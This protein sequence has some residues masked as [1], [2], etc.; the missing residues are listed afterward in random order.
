MSPSELAISVQGL[1]KSYPVYASPFDAL[2]EIFPGRKHHTDLPVL[3]DIS[4][5]VRRGERVG[6]VGANGAGKS[7]LLK[8][9]SGTV[10]HTSGSY[11]VEGQLRAILELGTGFHEE[12]TGRENILL[13]GLCLGYSAKD[14]S[15]R[16]DWIIEFSELA[17][18]MDRPLRTYSSGMKARLMYSVAFCKP[19]EIMIIDE[20]LA[21]GDASFVRKCTNH[22]V[23]LCG[24]GTTALIV[25]HNLY[26]LERI[27]HRVVYLADGKLVADGDPLEVC[28]LY[29]ADQGRAFVSVSTQSEV[30]GFKRDETPAPQADQAAPILSGGVEQPFVED[31]PLA[32]GLF[33][34]DLAPAPPEMAPQNGSG[35]IVGDDGVLQLFDFSGAPAVRHLNLVRLREAKLFDEQGQ[36]AIEI[37]CGRPCRVRFVLESRVVKRDVHIGF[38]IWN[39]GGDHVA[40]STNVCSLD[41]LGRPNGARI[42]LAVGLLSVDVVFPSLR[43]GAGRYTL[44]FGVSPGVEHYSDDDLFVSEARCLAFSVSRPDHVQTVFYEPHSLWSAPTLLGDLPA[45]AESAE[46][47]H[48]A[49]ADNTPAAADAAPEPT[50]PSPPSC[51]PATTGPATS[52]S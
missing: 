12:C 52:T 30:G 51:E 41:G 50:S 23:G 40:T 39:E 28:K 35:E 16:M 43:L 33:D 11:H 32:A 5:E 31:R 24:D 2:K 42:D 20:A 22:I 10:D 8:V 1:G 48:A 38:M 45:A 7:T 46:P 29:E 49:P 21:T 14:L 4:F 36:P 17:R 6:I 19:V 9:L 44:K 27:C 3:E 26:F 47:Q 15:E 13:G 25:S 37:V 34:P 18:V